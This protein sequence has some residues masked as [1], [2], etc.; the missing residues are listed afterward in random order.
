MPSFAATNE[1]Q[2]AFPLKVVAMKNRLQ[3]A[4]TVLAVAAGGLLWVGSLP[5]PSAS[6][7][8]G[9]TSGAVPTAASPASTVVGMPLPKATDCL[10]LP[11]SSALIDPASCW[12]TGLAS[13]LVAGTSPG[14]STQGAVAVISG[15]TEQLA[16]APGSG[17]LKVL[18][19]QGGSAWTSAQLTSDT[20]EESSNQA[21]STVPL[22]VTPSY[23]EYYAYVGECTSSTTTSTSTTTVPSSNSVTC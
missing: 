23:Y 21:S 10:D 9:S 8:P 14:D 13:M 16:A 5:A 18:S 6:T 1:S 15:Q 2:Q 11:I 22:P 3:I 12:D 4:T 17:T 19:V 7:N 20:V